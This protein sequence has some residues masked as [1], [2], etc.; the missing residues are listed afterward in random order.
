MNREED[1]RKLINDKI[2]YFDIKYFDENKDEAENLIYT[3]EF[4]N[5]MNIFGDSESG[6]VHNITRRLSVFSIYKEYYPDGTIYRKW[7][8]F[9]NGGGPVGIRYEFNRK[10]KL[11]KKTDMDEYY[12][13]T[14]QDIIRFC[15]EKEIDLYSNDTIVDKNYSEE[16]PKLYIINYRGKYDG[17]F[18]AR[19]VILLNG[20]TGHVKKVICIN[21]KHNDSIETLYEE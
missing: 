8:N 15:K 3:D 12:I 6:Y 18:G 5:H 1:H 16:G 14:P 11:I 19:I 9:R 17:T 21:G 2:E 4:G 7:V 13:I 10:G 20:E